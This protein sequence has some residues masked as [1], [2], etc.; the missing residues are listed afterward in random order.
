MLSD[1]AVRIASTRGTK[2]VWGIQEA[3]NYFVFVSAIMY[4]LMAIWK[5][6]TVKIKNVKNFETEALKQR[7]TGSTL[8]ERLL[9][10][11]W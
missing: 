4:Q 8:T 9:P 3:G 11:P 5:L 10:P 2:I 6:Q 7:G 1:A